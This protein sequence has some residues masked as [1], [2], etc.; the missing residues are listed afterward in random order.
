M[1]R[2]AWAFVIYFAVDLPMLTVDIV[3]LRLAHPVGHYSLRLAA[4]PQEGLYPNAS[5]FTGACRCSATCSQLLNFKLR[6]VRFSFVAA[7]F[8]MHDFRYNLKSNIEFLI[9]AHR[10]LYRIYLLQL[11][12]ILNFPNYC[13]YRR[14]NHNDPLWQFHFACPKSM[15]IN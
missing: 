15:K 1:L 7:P 3:V 12:Q 10:N 4:V 2:F 8:S 13:C 5:I 6:P 11:T 14:P 9:F